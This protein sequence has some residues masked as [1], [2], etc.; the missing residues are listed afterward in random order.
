MQELDG[1]VTFLKGKKSGKM[2][3]FLRRF[4]RKLGI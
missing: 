4:E 2:G 3:E 1:R